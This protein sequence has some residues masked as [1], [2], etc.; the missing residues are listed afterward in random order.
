M[1]SVKYYKNINNARM[2]NIA[3][4]EMM[5]DKSAFRAAW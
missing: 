2:P 4:M 1:Q 3:S 5:N